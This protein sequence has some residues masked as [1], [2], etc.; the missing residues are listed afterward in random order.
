MVIAKDPA[1]IVN[2]LDPFSERRSLVTAP[3][4][5]GKL[6][7]GIDDWAGRDFRLHAVTGWGWPQAALRCCSMPGTPPS[8]RPIRKT[9]SR[10]AAR[11]FGQ[12]SGARGGLPGI[13]MNSRAGGTDVHHRNE[14]IREAYV[15]CTRPA[16]CSHFA[17]LRPL[18]RP[19]L[20]ST[21]EAAQY[22]AVQIRERLRW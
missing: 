12:R 19:I 15:L 9:L 17:I 20:S 16:P 5:R 11:T 10:R 4:N 18:P 3:C 1:R 2:N 6:I 22:L 21:S 14:A 13:S 8:A 7:I